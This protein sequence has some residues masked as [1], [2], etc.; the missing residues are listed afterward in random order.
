ML[1]FK[2]LDHKSVIYFIQK[3]EIG[4]SSMHRKYSQYVRL[5][6]IFIRVVYVVFLFF[7]SIFR[8]KDRTVY[9]RRRISTGR[10][11]RFYQLKLVSTQR[12]NQQD[13]LLK[14]SYW[15][16]FKNW[17]QGTILRSSMTKC[18]GCEK[19]VKQNNVVIKDFHDVTVNICEDCKKDI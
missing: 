17:F 7:F 10:G 19:K 3:G 6:S 8:A 11:R 5:L 1:T 9:L 13:Q 15:Y 18:H 4:C 16:Q 14:N 12:K 2:G